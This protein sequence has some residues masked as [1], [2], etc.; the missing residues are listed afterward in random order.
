MGTSLNPDE[1]EQKYV[2]LMGCDLGPVYYR[3]QAEC[4][5]LN[6]TWR[7]FIELF[8]TSEERVEVLKWSAD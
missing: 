7:Q 2:E 3:L 8:A 4:T 1:V 5:L 6:S